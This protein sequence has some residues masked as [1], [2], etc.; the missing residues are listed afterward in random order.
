MTIHGWQMA[1]LLCRQIDDIDHNPIFWLP[2]EKMQ[3]ETSFFQRFTL[4]M[5]T[6]STSPMRALHQPHR[7]PLIWHAAR[8]EQVRQHVEHSI[9]RQAACHLQCQAFARELVGDC[10][11]LQRLAAHRAIVDEIPR[12]DVILVLGAAPQ[13]T[14]AAV[15]QPPPFSRLFRHPKPFPSPLSIDPFEV[16][17]PIFLAKFG[18]DHP[19]TVPRMLANQLVDPRY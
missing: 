15:P 2:G 14:V 16:H 3:E 12:P 4:E 17:P 7:G 1:S 10:K 19:I 9:G 8:Q 13:T 11:P 5:L 6:P 18:R